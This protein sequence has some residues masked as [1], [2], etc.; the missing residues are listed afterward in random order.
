LCGSI[1]VHKVA[2][3]IA[4]LSGSGIKASHANNESKTLGLFETLD[5]HLGLLFC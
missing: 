1:A 2:N 4:D 3:T 5:V